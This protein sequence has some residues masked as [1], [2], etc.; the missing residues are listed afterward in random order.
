MNSHFKICLEI[1]KEKEK[2]F[3]PFPLFCPVGPVAGPVHLR[4]RFP[5]GLLSSCPMAHSCPAAQ[6][7]CWP[8]FTASLAVPACPLCVA[9]RVGPPGSRLLPSDRVRAGLYRPPCPASLCRCVCR[10]A[11]APAP[12]KYRMPHARASLSK[13]QSKHRPCSSPRQPTLPLPQ[14]WRAV[15]VSPSAAP[16]SVSPRLFFRFR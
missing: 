3:P 7:Q 12:L 14:A 6:Q 11:Q 10:V 5:R 13:P 2:D 16:P 15:T 1:R 8:I 4:G 9:D